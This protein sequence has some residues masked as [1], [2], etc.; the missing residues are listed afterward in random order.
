MDEREARELRLKKKKRKR[1]ITLISL[2]MVV[3]LAGGGAYWAKQYR[4]KKTTEEAERKEQESMEEV[5]LITD[6]LSTEVTGVNVTNEYGNFEFNWVYTNEEEHLGGWVKKGEEDFPTKATAVQGVVGAM[7]RLMGTVRIPAEEVDSEK[8]GLTNPSV[9]VTVSMKERAAQ[10][11]SFGNQAPYEAG[12]YIRDD[13]TGDVY[14]VDTTV[15]NKLHLDVL[16]FAMMEMFPS[17][18]AANI[19]EVTVERKGNETAVYSRGADTNSNPAIFSEC[20]TFS[21]SGMVE[22]NC[23]DFAKYG[24]DDPY[25]VVTVLYND[26]EVDDS[27]GN[28]YTIP[29]MMFLKV[30]NETESGNYYVRVND[31]PYV[32]IM[33]K[34]FVGYYIK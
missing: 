9:T 31:S 33:T 30:G 14:L 20:T 27:D 28:Q 15:F 1:A 22:Y 8:F 5:F 21:V 16:D 11:Y 26:I 2:F 12:Y 6:I 19:T 18:Q 7:S 34:A 4:I 13:E 10:T 24:L 3:I 17:A 25:M 23:K 29:C 32:Y